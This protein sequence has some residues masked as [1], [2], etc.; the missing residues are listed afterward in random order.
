VIVD[1]DGY[2]VTNAHVANVSLPL[3]AR[4]NQR[5]VCENTATVA[6]WHFEELHFLGFFE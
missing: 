3:S 6:R 2:I 1:A 5:N 4:R